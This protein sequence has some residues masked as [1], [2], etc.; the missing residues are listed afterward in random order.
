MLDQ[1]EEAIRA[2]EELDSDPH[3]VDSTA[4]SAYINALA[5]AG[6]MEAALRMLQRSDEAAS[7]AGKSHRRA[8][9]QQ[10]GGSA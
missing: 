4:L 10:L 1:V 8:A 9:Q 7:Q 3:A 6:R 5:R 2:F